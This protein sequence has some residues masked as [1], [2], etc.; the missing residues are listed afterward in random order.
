MASAISGPYHSPGAWNGKRRR[1]EVR[2]HDGTPRGAR[3]SLDSFPP[4]RS[5]LD[6]LPEYDVRRSR[7]RAAIARAIGVAGI[8]GCAA[9]AGFALSKRSSGAAERVVALGE[10]VHFPWDPKLAPGPAPLPLERVRPAFPLSAAGL[11]VTPAP[12]FSDAAVAPFAREPHPE[13]AE[14]AT[15]GTSEASAGSS[16]PAVGTGASD[17]A[18]GHRD[19]V[20]RAPREIQSEFTPE[21]IR[22]RK[23][24]YEAWLRENGLERVR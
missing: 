14:S 11:P 15:L 13:S 17:G 1:V 24:R 5:A 7:R 6:S 20:A 21:E 8:L 19:E 22:T 9:L 4:G 12:E 10:R 3:N 18:A 23:E 16:E 2:R